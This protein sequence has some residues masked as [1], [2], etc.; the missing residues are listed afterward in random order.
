MTRSLDVAT[1]FFATL[2][3]IPAG[4]AVGKLGP[5][6]ELPLEL[7]EFEACPYGRKVREALTMLDLEAMI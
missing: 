3:R 7:Y 1:S 2:A 6:P 4:M 5:R